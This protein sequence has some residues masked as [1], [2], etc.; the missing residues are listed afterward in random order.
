MHMQQQ[1]CLFALIA[2]VDLLIQQG[3]PKTDRPECLDMI[4]GQSNE[5][6]HW[7]TGDVLW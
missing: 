5:V 4:G 6:S 3:P 7:S 1:T 2:E